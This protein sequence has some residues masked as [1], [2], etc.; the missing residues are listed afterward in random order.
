M[1]FEVFSQLADVV[2]DL[3]IRLTLV[4]LALVTPFL[5]PRFFLSM[6]MHVVYR[7]G[8]MDHA[9]PWVILH[10]FD[11]K[12]SLFLIEV[13]PKGFTAMFL[14]MKLILH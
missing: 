9:D 10:F 4:S 8:L 13:F 3:Y 7:R 14:T 2:A 12:L 1:I 6:L 11:M 5:N